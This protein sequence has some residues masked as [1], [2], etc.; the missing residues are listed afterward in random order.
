MFS[1]LDLSNSM[2]QFHSSN[3]NDSKTKSTVD[4]VTLPSHGIFLGYGTEKEE[5]LNSCTVGRT[6]T[7][8]TASPA[9]SG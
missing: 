1:L 5:K 4:T 9:P 8:G 7:K 6:C 3:R 2:L